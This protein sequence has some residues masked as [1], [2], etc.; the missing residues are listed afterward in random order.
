MTIP[1]IWRAALSVIADFSPMTYWE[2]S[3]GAR[4]WWTLTSRNQLRDDCFAEQPFS[5]TEIVSVCVVSEVRFRE[6]VLLCDWPA[7]HQGLL[8]V[9][10]LRVEEMCDIKIP[11]AAAP[12]KALHL[13]AAA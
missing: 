10:G 11:P 3:N 12:N 4:F 7:L 8:K 13:T 2:M 6:G 5:Y 1:E 9:P